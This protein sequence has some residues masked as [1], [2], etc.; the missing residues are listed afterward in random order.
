Y[1]A[2]VDT[3]GRD[4]VL[5]RYNAPVAVHG[6]EWLIDVPVLPRHIWGA[7]ARA[8][9]F[10]G[11]M[12]LVGCG[13]FRLGWVDV[14]RRGA[15]LLRA[16]DF[17]RPVGVDGVTFPH[18]GAADSLVDDLRRGRLDAVA[19]FSAALP[20]PLIQG[21]MD[22]GGPVR[23]V[24][25]AYAGVAR[26]LVFGTRGLGAHRTFRTAIASALD[27]GSLARSVATPLARRPALSFTPSAA[28]SA[29]PSAASWQGDLGPAHTAL[30]SQ[31]LH[32]R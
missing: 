30:S 13:P 18:R 14:D 22:S 31:G 10:S 16:G 21:L 6:V 28:W 1:L 7:V 11:A 19:T 25:S 9:T 29:A 23:L 15:T 5:V 32:A 24:S 12:A 4:S 17:P 26:A 8:D 20:A 3:V 27:F 2:R